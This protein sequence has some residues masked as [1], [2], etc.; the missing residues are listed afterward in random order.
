VTSGLYDKADNGEKNMTSDV[1]PP[2][3]LLRIWHNRVDIGKEKEE[4]QSLIQ[5][6]PAHQEFLETVAEMQ[7]CPE[8]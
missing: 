7:L 2:N 6:T 3:N 1:L 5:L 8:N 4:L